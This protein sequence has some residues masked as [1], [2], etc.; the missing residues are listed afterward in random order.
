MDAISINITRE[1]QYT[2][3]LFK[4]ILYDS[5]AHLI[6]MERKTIYISFTFQLHTSQRHNFFCAPSV[7]LSFK[8]L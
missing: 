6:K 3:N 1:I 4:Y 5:L 8:D 7:T 2:S